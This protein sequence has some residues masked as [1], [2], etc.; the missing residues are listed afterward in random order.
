MKKFFLMLAA[1]LCYLVIAK[2]FTSCTTEIVSNEP[3]PDNTPVTS[4]QMECVLQIAE[5]SLVSFDFF[6]RY[7]DADGNEKSEKVVWTDIEKQ[8]ASGIKY[9]Q[10]TKTVTAAL[11]TT[12]G[13]FFE[14]KPREDIDLSDP[15]HLHSYSYKQELTISSVRQS[16]ATYQF[17]QTPAGH[18]AS[19]KSSNI[20]G[21]FSNDQKPGVFANIIVTFDKNG[22]ITR[23]KEWQ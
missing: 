8:S 2:T 4:A 9:K 14:M 1:V 12:L 16:G 19:I 15:N 7:Y 18:S 23:T 17:K 6:V 10:W 3:L 5:V 22:N 11:P 20:Q 21:F 13:M